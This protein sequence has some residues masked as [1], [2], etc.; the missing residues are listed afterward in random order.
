[1]AMK[2]G[3]GRTPVI[4]WAIC[5][6]CLTY[7]WLEESALSR[8][9]TQTC[10]FCDTE[11]TM[12]KGARLA[13]TCNQLQA[14]IEEVERQIAELPTA[15]DVHRFIFEQVDSIAAVFNDRLDEIQ[16]A[17]DAEAKESAE[18]VDLKN[19]TG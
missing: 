6:G 3:G 15:I 4:F 2:K 14:I 18:T 16:A 5:P 11:I 10:S 19:K 7:T 8:E 12:A 17:K 13:E 1:M 9:E